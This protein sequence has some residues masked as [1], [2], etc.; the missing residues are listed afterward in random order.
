MLQSGTSQGD[1]FIYTWAQTG[2]LALGAGPWTVRTAARN[3]RSSASSSDGRKLGAVVYNEPL[4]AQPSIY[5]STD[6]GVT[7]AASPGAVGQPNAALSFCRVTSSADGTR[8]AA[9]ER[10]GKIY[11][12]SDSGLSWIA[13]APAG[14]FND[15]ASSSDGNTLVALQ[16][17]PNP[18]STVPPTGRIF[19]STDAGV[20]W[21]E[22]QQ[23]RFW[24]GLAVSA[25]GNRIV[26]GVNNGRIYTST[27]NRSTLGET[28]CISGGQTN[29]IQLRYLGD[30][31]FDVTGVNG[32][33]FTVN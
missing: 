22:R 15:I 7:W 16:P 13:R 3:W 30:G 31:L 27:S 4:D 20:T 10:F 6:F 21:I 25:D 17:V 1:G 24:R 28:S 2:A 14:G 26:A 18:R 32:P 29:D 19:I 5:L 8:L 11:C 12:S 33:P 23:A 9:A